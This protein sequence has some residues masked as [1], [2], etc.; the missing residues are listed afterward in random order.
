MSR[1]KRYHVYI[2]AQPYR[3]TPHQTEDLKDAWSNTK[4]V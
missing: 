2:L 3:Y 1:A 4:R